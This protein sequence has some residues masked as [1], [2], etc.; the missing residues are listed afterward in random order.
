MRMEA[1]ETIYREV[2]AWV[3]PALP[4]AIRR[5]IA[6]KYDWSLAD[7][8][9]VATPPPGDKR[10]L[11]APANYGIQ[12]YYWSRA[13]QTIPGVAAVNLRFVPPSP[14]IGAPN[15][16]RVP[17]NVGQ[18]SHIWARRQRKAIQ[19]NVTHILIEA[20][21]PVLG[22]LYE[23]D[24]VAEV[25]ALQEAGVKVGLVSH[26]SDIRS[27]GLHREL[28]PRS[29]FNGPL[30]GRTKAAE[31]KASRTHAIMDE[32]GVPEFVSTP[33]LLSFRPNATWLP[34]V[35]DPER[36]NH[37]AP[38]TLQKEKLTVMHLT[39]RQPALKGS[40]AISAAMKR[41]DEEGVIEYL[42]VPFVKYEELPALM[43][44]ADIVVNQVN[45]GLYAAVAVEAMFSGR[46][47]VAGVWDSVRETIKEQTGLELPIVE[48]NGD[49]VYG[50]VKRISDHREQYLP[51]A[52]KGREYAY[53]VHSPQQV[54]KV[55][56]EFLS[57]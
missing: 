42:E 57:S 46:V 27:P 8:R 33:D 14:A 36:W 16:F 13:A 52:Q 29:P 55:L 3:I 6:P 20:G 17:Q 11:I 41:L 23:G 56:E 34:L 2:S 9:T 53:A 25:R 18:S 30:D 31:E 43:E 45:M 7:L 22:A 28:E 37:I 26:G 47:V 24:L 12:G 44:K 50:V 51:L 1:K 4:K 40:D 32:L 49:N 21:R 15:Y 38:T 10:L 54:G 5:K 19:K 39:S 48:A 35:T